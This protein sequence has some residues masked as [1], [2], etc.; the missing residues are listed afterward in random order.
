MADLE[1]MDFQ[2]HEDLKGLPV[3]L[4]LQGRLERKDSEATQ[5]LMG[6]QG[7]RERQR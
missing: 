2:A 4:D 6:L 3:C 5:G 1:Q 7:S